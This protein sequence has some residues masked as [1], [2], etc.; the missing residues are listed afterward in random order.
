MNIGNGLFIQYVLFGICFLA[1]S[2]GYWV[3]AWGL[4][5]SSRIY[6]RTPDTKAGE[7]VGQ[8]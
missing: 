8:Q 4:R 1:G 6:V 7:T 5:D 3:F 2:I